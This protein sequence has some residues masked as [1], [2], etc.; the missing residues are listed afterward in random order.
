M[1]LPQL[2]LV[3]DCHPKVLIQHPFEPFEFL[4]TA[5]VVS[6]AFALVFFF[7]LKFLLT[8]IL[9]RIQR[10]AVASVTFQTSDEMY[11]CFGVLFL[12]LVKE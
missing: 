2:I 8:L 6:I 11:Y 4:F 3:P 10:S 12:G 1:K 5:V 9:S 7:L